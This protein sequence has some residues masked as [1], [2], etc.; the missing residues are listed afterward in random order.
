MESEATPAQEPSKN[1]GVDCPMAQNES[2]IE[3]ETPSSSAPETQLAE[4]VR[5]RR[6]TEDVLD[7]RQEELE[8]QEAENKKLRKKLESVKKELADTQDQLIEA[9]NQSKAKSKQLQ[10]AK[11][12]IFSLQP[13]RKDITESEAQE[14]YKRLCSNIQRWVENRLPATLDD[15]EAGRLRARPSGTHAGRFVS[16]IREPAKRCLSVY[17]SDEHHVIAVIMYYLWLAFFSKSFYC[18]LGGSDDDAT[19]M[20]IDELESAMSRLPRDPAHCREW[21]SETLTALT[22]QPLFKSR[23]ATYIN[24]VSEDLS[25]V[26][27][28]AVPKVAPSELQSSVRRTIVEP[29]ADFAHQLHLASNIYSLKWPARNASTRLEVYE[30]INLANGGL[31]L[32]LSGT[33]PSSP[34]RRKVSYLFDVAPGLFVERVEVGK[35]APL[36]AIYRPNVLVYAGEGEAPQ[37]PTLIKWLVDNSSGGGSSREQLPRTSAPRSKILSH[38]AVSKL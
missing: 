11:D 1:E 16:L 3:R 26:L 33:G 35:K 8:L 20:W 27:A 15:M 19:I 28:V 31:V 14:A 25:A 36:K 9:R 5:L 10:E 18:P 7:T 6:F 34:S 13:R 29:A 37:R 38:P 2:K 30:C 24:L 32:D 17:Q 23:R 4:E 22:A 21:R 12:Q